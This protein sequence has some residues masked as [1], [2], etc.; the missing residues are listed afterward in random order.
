MPVI[1]RTITTTLPIEDAFAY[2]SDFSNASEWDP[3][4]VT[5]KARDDRAP[6]V[7]QEYDLEVAWGDRRLDMV[8]TITKLEENRLLELEGDGSTTHAVDTMTFTTDGDATIVS[9]QAD[10]RLKGILRL[11]EPFLKSKFTSLGD[12]A[13]YGL[14]TAFAKRA[15]RPSDT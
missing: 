1:S 7:G 12:E 8:Y 6:Y 3:G 13:E 2:L 11:A 14:S 10:I 4:T 9:Y 5:S 15:S